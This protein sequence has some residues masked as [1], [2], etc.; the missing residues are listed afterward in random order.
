MNLQ[1]KVA[2]VTGASRGIGQAIALEL[3]RQGAIVIGTAT[4]S[5]GAERIAE[6]L[7]ENGIEGAGL[8]LDVSSDESVAA[9]LE[10][11]QQRLG[12]PAILVNN[13]GITRDNLMLRMKDDEWH[14]VIDTNLS[15]LYRLTKGVLRGMTKARWG[16]IISIGSV[17]GAMG[18]AGQVNYAAAKAGLEGFSRAL[19]REVGSRGI[20]VNAVAPG[21]IDTDMTR[22]L[23]DA[24][25]DA[26]L[27]Q[28]P[29]GRLGQAEEI[30]KVVAF[31][32]S[33]G[34]AYVTG[35]TVPVNGGMYMS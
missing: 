12:Q 14:D 16:R 6:T 15:S 20:T 13:A 34:A 28:I 4:S 10:H 25:R 5:A 26:L 8:V 2:L 32:A 27:G 19:A 21:F 31:L 22:E 9:T 29:L 7:K 17:V 24:Q 33:D 23:P 35:A 3:G 1:G 30:A 18:N 11:I